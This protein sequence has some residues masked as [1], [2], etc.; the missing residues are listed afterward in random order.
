MEKVLNYLRARAHPKCEVSCQGV[1]HRHF[2]HASSRPARQWRKLYH[3][4]ELTDLQPR[5]QVS[6]AFSHRLQYA[7]FVLQGK[8]AAN[9]AMDG[10]VRTLMPDV[11]ASKANQNNCSYVSSADLPS[12]SLCKNLAWWAVTHEGP[13]KTTKLSKLGGGHLLRYGRLLGIFKLD[14]LC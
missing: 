11:V 9:E 12:D 5:C 3:A 10:C 6:A 14:N 1:P 2:V 4:T 7:N 13:R 8:N